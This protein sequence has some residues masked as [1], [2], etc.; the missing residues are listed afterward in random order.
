MYTL[1]QQYDG[2]KTAFINPQDCVQAV[3]GFP[4][5]CVS[6]F[7]EAIINRF[8]QMDAV[9]QIASLYT[10]NGTLPVYQICYQGVDIAFYLSRVGAPA[11]V[12][13]FEEV[14][15]MGAQKFVLFGCCGVLN[16]KMADGQLVVPTAAVR[17]EGVSHQYLPAADEIQLDPAS[18]AAVTAAIGSS[19]YPFI[20]GKVWTT[21]APYRETAGKVARR[22]AQGCIAVEMECAAMVAA[23]RFRGIPF[24]Q[25][26]YAADTLDAPVWQPRSLVEYGLSQSQTYMALAFECALRL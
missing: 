5:L 21:D 19:G 17:D 10:A 9:R 4:A 23:A 12:V 8:A 18:I 25:F 16:H 24:A 3:P 13:G 11:C 7:S 20:P 26:L 22:K 2:A 15:A 1:Y 6:T 14:A